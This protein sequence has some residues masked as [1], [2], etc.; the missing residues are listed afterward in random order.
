MQFI[1]ILFI[2]GLVYMAASIRIIKEYDRGIIY[3]LGKYT[4]TRNPG[5]NFVWL[6]FQQM[7]TVDM[8]IRTE[9]IPSQDVISKDNVSITTELLTIKNLGPVA[10]KAFLRMI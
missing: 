6:F 10:L 1:G 3:T 5:L 9:D 2:A 4:G 8:R 7:E